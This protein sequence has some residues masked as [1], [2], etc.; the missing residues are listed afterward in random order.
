MKKKFIALLLALGLSCA[1]VGIVACGEDESSTTPPTTENPDTGDGGTE[2]PDDGEQKP[3]DGT[4]KP[5]DGTQKPDDGTETPDKGDNET[6]DGTGDNEADDGTDDGTGGGTDDGTG[7][8][9]QN[10]DTGD[11]TETPVGPTDPHTSGLEFAV[12]EDGY[13]V[14]GYTGTD[15]DIVIPKTYKGK[16]VLQLKSSLFYNNAT[17][18]SVSLP[19][20]LVSIGGGAFM[21]CTGLTGEFVLP[22]SVREIGGSTFYNCSGITSVTI[23]DGVT[24]ISAAM[25]NGCTMLE[26]LSIPSTVAYVGLNAFAN[27][28]NLQYTTKGTGSY[29]GNAENPCVV[30]MST[31]DKA[32]LSSVVDGVK[33]IYDDVFAGGTLTGVVALPE[34]IGSIGKAA[35]KECNMITEVRFPDTLTEIG[36]QAF[37]HCDNI[38][39]V[40]LGSGVTSIG[41]YAFYYCEKIVEV[42]DKSTALT[43][44]AGEE[45]KNGCVAK[46]AKSVVESEADSNIAKK[47]GYI[48][49]ND[50]GSYALIGY[51]GAA[52][53]L[54]LPENIKDNAYTIEQYAFRNYVNIEGVTIPYGV[55]S[56]GGWAFYGCSNLT[57]V[58]IPDS[59]TSIGTSAFYMA[60]IET[61]TLPASAIDDVKYG[62]LKTVKITGG[63]IAYGALD[64]S[65][66]LESV[67]IGK[68]VTSIG[69]RVFYCCYN[70]TN[71]TV[72]E[73]NANYKSVDGN[74]YSK[75]G[76]VLVQYA[77]GKTDASFTIPEGVSKIGEYSFADAYCLRSITIPSGVTNIDTQA[78]YCC[79]QLIEV[80]DQSPLT[81][82][83]KDTGNGY[84]GYYAKQ[85]LTEA[86]TTSNFVEQDG[87][88]FFNDNETYYLMDYEGTET[89]LTLPNAIKDHSYEIYAN[90]FYDC[91]TLTSVVI[92]NGVT[93]IG[94]AAFQS[95]SNLAS[96][97]IGETVEK[98]DY[99][100]FSACTS[101]TSIILPNGLETLNNNVLSACTNLTSVVIGSNV[102]E[103]GTQAFSA[104]DKLTE[105]YYCGTTASEWDA[106][107]IG[108]DN[109]KLNS[110]ARYYYSE[111]QP[112][113]T[114]NFWH[115]V[116]GVVTKW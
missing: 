20:G 94:R 93:A 106:I 49:Y 54:V 53:D 5:D 26:T 11:N 18:T 62:T 21:G 67:I 76:T 61:A 97:T 30:L 58:S 77:I 69:S 51:E 12:Y 89:D 72:E 41:S 78:F 3:D 114:G 55:T 105:V 80:I 96:V 82:T 88:V 16:Q 9:P 115:Y 22:S 74:L 64:Y 85:V 39:S 90:A 36:M 4:Q 13:K 23:P 100:A 10:P 8:N 48:F 113:T 44:V 15:T 108:S 81:I 28:D 98:I 104:C 33:V 2:N 87:Y 116:D 35:F 84:V 75:D 46:Y 45:T 25:F 17:I 102:K 34:G 86:P 24:S 27:C 14:T 59:V 1:C 52:T 43:I 112:T 107:S 70:L 47:D 38:T 42:V 79:Y 71:I 37:Y 95:C 65:Y 7:D 32:T 57:S 6:G 103:V 91:D 68:D 60:S 110:A 56:I 63:E 73:D 40:T 19:D 99:F 31:T 111:E 109:T 50:N 101:L 66:T 29:L 92:P 83:A